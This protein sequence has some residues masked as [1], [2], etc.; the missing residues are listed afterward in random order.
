MLELEFNA[1]GC[2]ARWQAR[3]GEEITCMGTTQPNAEL[4][5]S[6]KNGTGLVSG[7]ILFEGQ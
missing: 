7:H 2:I 5:L 3:I 1:F 6:A 4:C